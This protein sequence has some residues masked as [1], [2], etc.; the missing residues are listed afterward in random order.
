LKFILTIDTEG[1]NQWDHGRELTVE[2]IKYVPRFQELCEKY[3]IK[4][5]YLVTSEVCDDSFAREIFTAY[6]SA[7][8]A[9][10]GAHLHSWTTPPFRDKDGYRYN[11]PNHAFATELPEDLL[12]EKIKALNKQIETSF[13]KP[14]S[15]FRSGRYGFDENIARILHENGYLIDT[16]VTPYTSW[17]EHKGMPGGKG[18]PDFTVSNSFPYTYNY[19]NGSI[20]E[21]PITILPTRFPMNKSNAL[22][23]YYFRN[24]D[25]SFFLRVFRK[26]LYRRQPLWLRPLQFMSI[27]LFVELLNAAKKISLP[28]LVMMFHSSELMPGCSIYRPDRDSIDKLYDLLERFFVLLRDENIPSVT[29]TEA[30]KNY[31]K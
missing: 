27:T 18:G 11:D 31:L 15:S 14:P 8:K 1:D 24:V 12:I 25:K 22:A 16:S 4:P 3:S 26:L 17:S 20:L 30:A 6:S 28:Y 21:I 2:N 5:T 9:E 13:G 7:D 23:K 29:L 10:I 19:G